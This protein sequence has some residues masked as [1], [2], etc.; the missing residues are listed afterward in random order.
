MMAPK[1]TAAKALY[2]MLS[3]FHLVGE[4]TLHSVWHC[5]TEG[6]MD[7]FVVEFGGVSLIIMANENDDSVDVGASEEPH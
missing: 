4:K 2:P 6:S 1:L 7:R 5:Y 3:A